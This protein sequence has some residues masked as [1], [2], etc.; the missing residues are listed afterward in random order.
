MAVVGGAG[1]PSS[2]EY[3]VMKLLHRDDASRTRRNGGLLDIGVACSDG[4]VVISVAGE[5][6]I[7]NYQHLRECLDEVTTAGVSEVILDVEHLTFMD[8]AGLS[9]LVSCHK[10]MEAE[11]GSFS[12]LAPTNIV[13]RLFD[14]TGQ[15]PYQLT[16]ALAV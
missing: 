12:I 14:V 4:V 9:V 11:G 16:E 3:Q 15:L 8:S 13:K 7:S 5:L 1:R 10:R 6:D 2:G